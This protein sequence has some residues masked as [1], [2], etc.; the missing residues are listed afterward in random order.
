VFKLE[1]YADATVLQDI[2]AS[3]SGAVWSLTL[4]SPADVIKARVQRAS[5]NGGEVRGREVLGELLRKEGPLALFKGLNLKLMIVG[6]KLMVS[7]TIYSQLLARLDRVFSGEGAQRQAL[8]PKQ[9]AQQQ[10]GAAA[11]AA[12]AADGK[13]Q[14][15]AVAA[16]PTKQGKQQ[17]QP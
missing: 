5:L 4:S 14:Q 13:G 6:P 3:T 16:S 1:K 2:V 15:T 11:V 10:R 12:A 9:Q 17:S 8:Q 7:F